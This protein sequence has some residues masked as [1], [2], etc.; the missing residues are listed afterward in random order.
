LL[1]SPIERLR[2]GILEIR[3]GKKMAL[4]EDLV[5]ELIIL[6]RG[7]NV[8][9]RLLYTL[10]AYEELLLSAGHGDL[11]GLAKNHRPYFDIQDEETRRSDLTDILIADIFHN[12]ADTT[13]YM[14]GEYSKSVKIFM[15]CRENRIYP[16]L[17]TMRNIYG[18]VVRNGD[19]SIWTHQALASSARGLPSYTRNGNTPAGILTIDSV[20]PLADQQI[21][22]GQFRRIILNF[23]P[24]SKDETLMQSL[25]PPSSRISD[26]WRPA[27]SA[28]DIGRNLLRIHGT[29]KIN[30]DPNT[31]YFPFMRT[32][33]CI[34]QK[35][36]T[37]DGVTY[38]DQQDL[39]DAIMTAMDLIP[40]FDNEPRVKG[41]LYLVEID[42]KSAP[43]QV[44]DL[45]LRGIQ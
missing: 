9:V 1:L 26:W 43:V 29:G 22:F 39:L 35:E 28:R 8:E 3:Y 5:D 34:S 21:S 37:Y 13:T 14:N 15:F 40:S 12:S 41:F 31:P 27:V 38:K 4:S 11:I 16:C 30:P 36:N 19:G 17:M 6:L 32:S 2:L 42:D 25:L 10:A 44:N 24:K 23:V 45:S 20:M 7:L 33:G 18:E